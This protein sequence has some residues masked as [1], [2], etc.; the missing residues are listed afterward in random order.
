MECYIHLWAQSNLFSLKEAVEINGAVVVVVEIE[1][2]KV[3]EEEFIDVVN[4]DK[5]SQTGAA[6]CYSNIISWYQ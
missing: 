4:S 5:D 2:V 3:E 6:A 1:I